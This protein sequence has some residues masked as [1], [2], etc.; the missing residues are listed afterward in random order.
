MPQVLYADTEQ[1]AAYYDAYIDT[2]LM[3]D[4]A[5][6]GGINDSLRFRNVPASG[7]AFDEISKWWTIL[8]RYY[9]AGKGE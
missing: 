5:E 1:R 4:V 9:H 7:C 6:L 8:D 3:R 2:Y